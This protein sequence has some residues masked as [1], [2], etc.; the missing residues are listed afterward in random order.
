MNKRLDFLFLYLDTPNRR[1][2]GFTYCTG[3]AKIIW[4]LRS[5][6]YNAEQFISTGRHSF[7]ELAS[8]VTEMSPRFVG[9]TC[10]DDDFPIVVSIARHIKRLAP[11][12][13]V[14]LGGPA[15]MFTDE[16][17]LEHYPEIDLCVRG[18]GEYACLELLEAQSDLYSVHGLTYRQDGKIRRNTDRPPMSSEA[19]N[20][21]PS[22][23]AQGLI[24]AE[25][26]WKFGVHSS[27]GC[28]FQC[29][30]C[31]CSA[32]TQSRVRFYDED[33]FLKEIDL[34][35]EYY[36]SASHEK[37]ASIFICDEAFTLNRKRVLRLCSQLAERELPFSLS[38]MT[39]GDLVDE[40]V[41]RALYAAGVRGLGFGLETAVPAILYN[42]R[43]AR[44]PADTSTCCEIEERFLRTF[45]EN[46]SLAMRMGFRVFAE[47][48]VG[49]PGETREDAL[50]TLETIK[51]LGVVYLHHTLRVFHGTR[52]WREH[53]TYGIHVRKYN[54]RWHMPLE[55]H[56]AYDVG[57]VPVLWE[58]EVYLHRSLSDEIQ[59]VITAFSGIGD[60]LGDPRYQILC[61]GKVERQGLHRAVG[62]RFRPGTRLLFLDMDYEMVSDTLSDYLFPLSPP[63]FLTRSPCSDSAEGRVRLIRQPTTLDEQSISFELRVK[64]LSDLLEVSSDGIVTVGNASERPMED[65]PGLDM[66]IPSVHDVELLNRLE[67]HLTT[68]NSIVFRLNSGSLRT[69]CADHCQLQGFP[70]AEGNRR[71][72]LDG[73]GRSVPT[74]GTFFPE[75]DPLA[76]AMEPHVISTKWKVMRLLVLA[77]QILRGLA[78]LFKG[79][80]RVNGS[81]EV[82]VTPNAGDS[83]WVYGT[84][85]GTVIRYSLARSTL[86]VMDIGAG[87]R[88]Q[89]T[90]C[91]V[92]SHV[93]VVSAEG[94]F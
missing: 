77:P 45:E 36:S 74:L 69:V 3:T 43:K 56:L 42:V 57:S 92:G 47:A 66:V 63:I 28:V 33:V 5:S 10:Y 40:E 24:P 1:F 41:L 22:V 26:A 4:N 93:G 86:Q 94:P 85:D 18:E 58:Q 31:Q 78:T 48:I 87:G 71:D 37:P 32:L 13:H 73:E 39:R 21:F 51:R 91:L 44:R 34:L 12:I 6:G 38:C 53:E 49:L 81:I 23:Y 46:V 29:T 55:T 67:S 2:E 75:L 64:T 11:K 70:P 50:A 52:L 83:E 62:E 17:I 27:R 59:S 82:S 68:Q 35:A 30:F 72:L 14:V 9:M 25:L 7:Q 16:M 19:M 89:T 8:I 54:N 60:G 88:M 76:T 90:R 80:D 79:Q 65:I 20:S 84:F 61:H 15:V